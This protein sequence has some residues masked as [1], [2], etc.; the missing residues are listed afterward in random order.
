MKLSF[1]SNSLPAS[2]SYSERLSYIKNYPVGILE[3]SSADY[4]YDHIL[5]GRIDKNQDS[6]YPS[7]NFLKEIPDDETSVV[8]LNFVADAFTTFRRNMDLLRSDGMLYA[9]GFIEDTNFLQPLRGWQNVNSDYDSFINS[10]YSNYLFPFLSSPEINEHIQSFQD[11]VEQFTILIDR[12]TLLSPFTKT[13]Y[14]TSN[15]GTPMYSGL[16]VEIEDSLDH[17]DDLE[18][19]LSYTNDS[20]FEI[21]RQIAA[22]NGFVLDKNAPWRLLALPYAPQIQNH[23]NTYGIN[24]ETMVDKYYYRS[25]HFDI[26]NLKVYMR[27]FYNAFVSTLPTVRIPLVGGKGK[28]RSLTKII[29][30]DTISKEQYDEEWYFDNSFW[31]RL[32]V[33]IRAK[34]T[35]RDW[36]QY[37]L[38]QVASKAAEF[39][40]YSGEEAAYKF[41]NK[42]V[43]RPWK[44]SSQIDKYRRGTFMLKRKRG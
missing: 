18:K 11:F 26:P 10:F 37:K 21:Y 9:G 1:G 6:I 12:T 2:S 30:R 20:N 38:D 31:I 7:Q 4:W 43:R 35:N 44:E 33:F 25:H 14:I 13:E 16:A 17:G 28:K 27:E 29:H 24:S 19:I 36:N 42:E 39:F 15:L 23:M 22:N 41:I 34:E 8:A 32:Y 40:L 5:F 3:Q